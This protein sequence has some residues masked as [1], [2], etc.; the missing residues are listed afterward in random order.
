[1]TSSKVIFRPVA[2]VVD[3][4][5]EE[6][7]FFGLH[8][9]VLGSRIFEPSGLDGE[10][11]DFSPIIKLLEICE[12]HNYADRTRNCAGIREN[13]IGGYRDVKPSARGDTR[14]RGDFRMGELSN[15]VVDF[16]RRRHRP[17]G[18][19]NPYHEGFHVLILFERLQRLE[20]FF[21]IHNHAIDFEKSD[22]FFFKDRLGGSPTFSFEAFGKE[23]V[24]GNHEDEKERSGNQEK[25]DEWTPS[26]LRLTRGYGC[27]YCRWISR[28][29]THDVFPS[30][31]SF[32]LQV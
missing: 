23:N 11:F 30:S 13:P 6:S 2:T 18:R 7:L 24:G 27:G 26:P 19:I 15:G 3:H 25:N 1:V 9:A 29:F 22:S 20:C 4:S 16:L 5:L 10:A 17:P 14:H 8:L 28:D 12:L 32:L 21:R 31:F